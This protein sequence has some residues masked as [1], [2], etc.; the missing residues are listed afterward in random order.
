VKRVTGAWFDVATEFTIVGHLRP[1]FGCI[2]LNWRYP[3][4]V[5]VELCVLRQFVNCTLSVRCAARL[6]NCNFSYSLFTGT[7]T[8]IS[9]DFNPGGILRGF[10]P[11]TRAGMSVGFFSGTHADIS[12][13]F[14][15]PYIQ[16]SLTIS[17]WNTCRYLWRFHF[18]SSSV[19]FIS[20]GYAGISR[21]FILGT[22]VDL[23]HGLIHGIC[24]DGSRGFFS[25]TCICGSYDRIPGMCISFSRI[26][27]TF[28]DISHS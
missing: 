4:K 6:H 26:P 18:W 13:G 17:F 15:L 14:L 22:C 21:G 28:T 2:R 11:G 23:W 25:R 8:D 19:G 16:M 12:G 24:G 10:I 5:E 7:R 3:R 20:G 27:G 1:T 9:P